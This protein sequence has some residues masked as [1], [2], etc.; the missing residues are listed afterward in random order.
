MYSD[1]PG[2]RHAADYPSTRT[3]AAPRAREMKRNH[4]VWLVST[5]ARRYTA[6][7]LLL[8]S[9]DLMALMS[10]TCLWCDVRP[11]D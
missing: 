5:G 6:T 2:T 3:T 4:L 9:F 7:V 11:S 10:C 1:Y 8:H